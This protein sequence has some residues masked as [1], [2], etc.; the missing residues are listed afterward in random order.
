VRGDVARRQP[1]STP[2][3]CPRD[4][5][6][7]PLQPA[8][9]TATS[10]L[11]STPTSL[12]AAFPARAPRTGSTSDAARTETHDH[13]EY[14]I[15]HSRWLLAGCRI[16]DNNDTPP[17]TSSGVP[18]VQLMFLPRRGQR[19]R[20]V[21]HGRSPRHR[22]SRLR[23]QGCLR[24]CEPLAVVHR[25]SSWAAVQLPGHQSSMPPHRRFATASKTGDRNVFIGDIR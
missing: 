22:Q 19:G 25:P 14:S 16:P 12:T 24:S 10:P 21:A 13:S 8:D 1:A 9:R 4:H 23:G 15:M 7:P 6:R 20:H 2:G 5:S 11:R 18:V 17:L 3:P